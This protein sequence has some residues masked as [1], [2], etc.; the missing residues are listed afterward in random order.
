MKRKYLITGVLVILCVIVIFTLKK[1]NEKLQMN[2]VEWQMED[3]N[4]V[5]CEY[6]CITYYFD[7]TTFEKENACNYLR[8][9]DIVLEHMDELYQVERKKINIYIGCKDVVKK[10]DTVEVKKKLDFDEIWNIAKNTH[11]SVIKLSLIH[12]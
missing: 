8:K 4:T 9:I 5:C 7:K 1:E 11:G 3:E 10:N 2:G 12:I 6:N